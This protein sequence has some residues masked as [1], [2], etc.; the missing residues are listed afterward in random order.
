MLAAGIKTPV[1][2]EEL[3]IHLREEIER[4]MKSGV[5]EPGAFN[6]AIRKIGQPDLL[7]SEFAKTG[8]L[9]GFLSK[10]RTLKINLSINGLLGLIWLICLLNSYAMPS[11]ILNGRSLFVFLIAATRTSNGQSLLVFLIVC[12]ALVGSILLVF[13]SKWGRSIIRTIALLSLFY[14]LIQDCL[15]AYEYSF[16]VRSC[17][18]AHYISFVFMLVSILILHL[19]AKA[20]L[21]TTVK[22]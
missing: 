12:A 13:D 9:H 11:P 21:K 8:G 4:Q 3:E 20:N 5:K 6:V 18:A 2:L 7:N 14:W 15:F 10:R 17:L 1:P 19:P 16:S 22:L